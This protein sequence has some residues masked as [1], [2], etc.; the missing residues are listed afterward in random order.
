MI[1]AV[2]K[3]DFSWWF[4]FLRQNCQLISNQQYF[5]SVLSYVVRSALY[6]SFHEKYATVISVCIIAASKSQ[7]FLLKVRRLLYFFDNDAV[8]F[9]TIHCN[10]F[11]DNTKHSISTKSWCFL[12]TSYTNPPQGRR[13]E[14]DFVTICVHFLTV[15]YTFEFSFQSFVY[16]FS[17]TVLLITFFYVKC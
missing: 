14:S 3:I 8:I 11:D 12:T 17:N 6:F 9:T 15:S 16:F 2:V 5:I 13:S 4:A 1:K 7:Q 10:C